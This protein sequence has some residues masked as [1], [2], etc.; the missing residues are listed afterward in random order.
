[1]H[2]FIVRLCRQPLGCYYLHACKVDWFG[3]ENVFVTTSNCDQLHVSA[4]IGA[5]A[6][7][8]IHGTIGSV[9]CANMCQNTLYPV[10]AAFKTK[11]KDDP[12]HVPRCP[13]CS[14]CLRPNVMI[15]GD[16]KL[17]DNELDAQSVCLFNC[18]IV[19]F[20]VSVFRCATDE[21]SCAAPSRLLPRV[22]RFYMFFW[23]VSF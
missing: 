23:L 16:D 5:D 7:Y 4:G 22:A 2:A 19:S 14:Y 10:D 20:I 6:L 3:K 21:N 15:F 9:Q 11:L 17:V 18:S 8:E 12:A 13:L 1:M